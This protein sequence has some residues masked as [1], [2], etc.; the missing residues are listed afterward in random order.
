M[1][2]KVPLILSAMTQC[3]LKIFKNYD[4]NI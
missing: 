1:D 2:T 3:L 4:I